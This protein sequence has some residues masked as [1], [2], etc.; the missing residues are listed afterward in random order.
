MSL[1]ETQNYLRWAYPGKPL[2]LPDCLSGTLHKTF[3]LHEN[4]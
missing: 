4:L 1:T 3:Y 2:K